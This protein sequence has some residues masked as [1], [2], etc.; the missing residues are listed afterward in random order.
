VRAG[1]IKT[2]EAAFD[3]TFG[4]D[5]FDYLAEHLEDARIF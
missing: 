3:H 1:V 2:G 4:Q 5:F